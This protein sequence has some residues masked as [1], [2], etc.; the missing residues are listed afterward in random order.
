VICTDHAPHH[1]D[2][3]EREFDDAPNGII[4]L[5]TALGLAVTELVETG[6]LSL[7]Q[8]VSRMSTMPARVFNL[9]GG[10]LAR[11]APADVVVLDPTAAWMVRPEEFFSKSRNTPFA[12]RR[13]TG[14]AETTIVRG[15]VVF[16]R[17]PGGVAGRKGGTR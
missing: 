17:E 10:T 9:P 12:G 5:E 14:R 15:Q 13:L 1:Y 11:G 3:K 7:D 16:A 4:G 2:A 6:L 8:L